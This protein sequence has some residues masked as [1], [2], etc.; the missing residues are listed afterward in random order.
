[1][2]MTRKIAIAAGAVAAAALLAT[3]VRAGEHERDEDEDDEHAHHGHSGRGRNEHERDPGGRSG[4]ERPPA[5]AA[6]HPAYAKECG[7]CHL[8][9]PPNLLPAASWSEIMAGLDRHFGQNAEI[10][11]ESRATIERWLV[12]RAR[13]APED[14]A[15]LRLTEGAWFR[16]KHRKV[17]DAAARPSV[18]S[19]ANCAACHPG[20]ERWDF[21]EDGVK[22]PR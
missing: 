1:M 11:A 5:S 14:G 2:S 15:P 6:V 10:D 12:E 20:A 8:A 3:A 21:D 7:S 4:G 17:Q 13:R 18:G 16:R 19:L 22:I 9:F